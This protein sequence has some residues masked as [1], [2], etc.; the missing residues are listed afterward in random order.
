MSCIICH[1]PVGA[2]TRDHCVY[3]RCGH[4]AHMIPCAATH[5]L[6]GR[7]LCICQYDSVALV[8]GGARVDWGFDSAYS[9]QCLMGLVNAHTSAQG[10]SEQGNGTFTLSRVMNMLANTVRSSQAPTFVNI[11][12]K[13][14]D[15][16]MRMHK[17]PKELIEGGFMINMFAHAKIDAERLLKDFKYTLDELYDLGIGTWELLQQLGFY[18]ELFVSARQ[19][20]SIGT[21]VGKYGVA[22]TDLCNLR[23]LT[24]TP[25]LTVLGTIKFS[26]IELGAL[27]F[28]F[29]QL[30]HCF[31]TLA[32]IKEL[33]I[34]VNTACTKFMLTPALYQAICARG[35][36]VKQL[37][38]WEELDFLTKPRQPNVAN[39]SFITF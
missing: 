8:A 4:R 30:E 12:F 7:C 39:L 35:G 3:P 17:S 25:F 22:F 5:F 11:T 23:Q 33:Q 10:S 20:I 28:T 13:N 19:R 34:D 32:D 9:E 29:P 2:E 16:A 14:L 21:L 31:P 36:P 18:L 6:M 37:Y 38:P 1:E 15:A 24:N 26:S 27:K